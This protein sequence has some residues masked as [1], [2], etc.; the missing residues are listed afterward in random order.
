MGAMLEWIQ[1][2]RDYGTHCRRDVIVRG[3]ALLLASMLVFVGVF[4]VIS[5]N[6]AIAAGNAEANP[7]VAAFQRHW[8]IW[9]FVPKLSIH[10]ALAVVVLWLP[11]RRMIRNARVGVAIYAA[12]IISNFHLAGWIL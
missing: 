1:K 12:I 9:W 7:L 2:L 6:A 11:S 5:T 4:D 10:I 3:A 8:G